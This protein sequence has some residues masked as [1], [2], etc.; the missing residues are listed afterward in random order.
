MSVFLWITVAVAM[1][2]GGVLVTVLGNKTKRRK[3]SDVL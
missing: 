2:V 1:F 3:Q